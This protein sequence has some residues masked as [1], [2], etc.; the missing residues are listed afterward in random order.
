MNNFYDLVFKIDIYLK[1]VEI[2]SLKSI[3]ELF[4]HKGIEK[5]FWNALCSNE[6]L[7]HNSWFKLL[8]ENDM[9]NIINSMQVE[10]INDKD[11]VSYW[12]PLEYLEKASINLK[13]S[14]NQEQIYK[15]IN[16]LIDNYYELSKKEYILHGHIYWLTFN[17]LSNLNAKYLSLSHLDF[18]RFILLNND[19][20]LISG[21]L[22]G[23]F[24]DRI[25]E[26]KNIEIIKSFFDLLLSFEF[27]KS[28]SGEFN[29]VVESYWLKELK[30]D[31]IDLIPSDY[32]I[33]VLSITLEKVNEIL[34]Y[35]KRALDTI[36]FPSIEKSSQERFIASDISKVCI[37]LAR[38][39]LERIEPKDIY[40]NV[41]YLIKS[42][43]DIF[44]RLSIHAINYHYN[45]LKEIFWN[46]DYNPID[47]SELYHELYKLFENHKDDF[48]EDE[49]KRII[50][51]NE[52]KDFEYLKK[53]NEYDKYKDNW[54]N[55][56]KRKILYA[57]EDSKKHKVFK[58][59][60]EKYDSKL[61]FEDEHPEFD[62][63]SESF[64]W[65]G[66]ESPIS[67][68]QILEMN[69]ENLVERFNNFKEPNDFKN[70]TNK[71]GFCRE[72]EKTI[73]DNYEK[74]INKLTLLLKIPIDYQHS[75][76][77]ALNSNI[78]NYS[79]EELSL[80]INY[81]KKLITHFEY[82]EKRNPLVSE[83]SEFIS[84][85]SLSE[86]NIQIN[87]ESAGEIIDL[88]DL[89]KERIKYYNPLESNK[90]DI[91]NSN[92]GQ[93]Y[94]SIIIFSLKIARD[95]LNDDESIKWN[96]KLKEII[97]TDMNTKKSFQLFEVI[98]RYL[99]NLFYL[100]EN[101]IKGKLEYLFMSDFNIYIESSYK[102]YFSNHTVYLKIFE[103]LNSIGA[104]EKALNHTFKEKINK[105]VV[106]FI[107]ISFISDSNDK[108]VYK[109][110]NNGDYEQKQKLIQF[111]QNRGNGKDIDVK[112]HIVP[113]W[114]Q[115]LNSL[116]DDKLKSL[117]LEL[118]Q[119]INT[120]K[121]IDDKLYDL[122]IRTIN[123]I[124][125]IPMYHSDILRNMYKLVD[126]NIKEVSNI[127]VLLLEKFDFYIYQ[128]EKMISIVES[129]YKAE[130]IEE[131]N[132][133][134]NILG[135]KGNYK[136]KELYIKHN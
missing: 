116:N 118:L 43:N 35:D 117:N 132:R 31:K 30:K 81:I 3:R 51:W 55:S 56:D 11:F 41:E 28:D 120:I 88:F 67:S 75:I 58:E 40:E 19:K 64:E 12:Q 136:F 105:K 44:K 59:E 37:D 1:K 99:P 123:N 70:K 119:W 76:L 23:K 107:C 46:I 83:F 104:I 103:E 60:F 79:I 71:R 6:S 29:S 90:S 124:E 34:K 68:K 36:L 24:F 53:L 65:I 69:I 122:I 20:T 54:I 74:F 5:Y 22:G 32:K 73:A 127:L 85:I 134:V 15:I 9:F 52:S 57:L 4:S 45:D 111:F 2:D 89:L 10:R 101:W 129:I 82:T 50:H 128:N 86:S 77:R 33:D 72:I 130:L 108:L 115:L 80:Y 112:K 100:D 113:L 91:L 13:D 97:E 61:K 102:G 106:E 66:D 18:I 93:F 21:N 135:E 42:K 47:K 95:K 39:L 14:N 109:V 126:D 27:G 133:I 16:K 87:K 96:L 48:S 8:I 121:V 110:I 63:Y 17:V 114:N 78:I 94:T 62:S 26:T 7:E 49:A 98:G 25:F 125:S 84:K 131:A 92:E 38:D